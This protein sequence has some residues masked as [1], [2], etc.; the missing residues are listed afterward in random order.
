MAIVTHLAMIR[1]NQMT[2]A[3]FAKVALQRIRSHTGDANAQ[4]HLQYDQ[5]HL[6]PRR[7]LRHLVTVS[8]IKQLK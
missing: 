7:H 8:E 6:G 3:F 1:E 2:A 4:V 5:C